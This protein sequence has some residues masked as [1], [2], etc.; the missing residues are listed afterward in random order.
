MDRSLTW[1]LKEGFARIRWTDTL[2]LAREL[3]PN[4]GERRRREGVDPATGRRFVHTAGISVSEPEL[5]LPTEGIRVRISVG[6]GEAGVTDLSIFPAG[7]DER[8]AAASPEKW[9]S[10]VHDFARQLVARLGLGDLPK[11]LT[12]HHWTLGGVRV[13]LTLEWDGFDLTV[14]PTRP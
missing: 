4:A 7:G 12:D 5:P 3:Y 2:P 6:F 8:Y 10:V 13:T 9:S 11:P 1:D 14:E